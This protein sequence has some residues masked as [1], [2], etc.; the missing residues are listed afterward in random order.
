MA[1][2]LCILRDANVTAIH[3]TATA[4]SRLKIRS[5]AHAS[6][7]DERRGGQR[8]DEWLPE[9]EALTGRASGL[10]DANRRPACRPHH[11]QPIP[12]LEENPLGPDSV[13]PF[14]ALEVLGRGNF[15]SPS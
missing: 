5:P 2:G 12:L 11:L 13:N 8:V 14:E 6:D 10:L 9:I 4:S 3:S 7:A 1:A 15:K